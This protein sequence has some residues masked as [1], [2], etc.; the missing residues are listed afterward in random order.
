MVVERV[1]RTSYSVDVAAP[2]GVLYG[3]VADTTQWPLFVPAGVH[4]ERLDFDGTRDR[5]SMWVTA[6]GTVRPSRSRRTLDPE[7][8]RIEFREEAPVAPVTSAGG[9]WS[10]DQLAPGWS[11]LTLEQ[12]VTVAGNRS[13]DVDLV[14]AATHKASRAGLTRLKDVAEKWRSLD[15]LTLTFEDEVR[16]RGPAEPVYAFLYDVA[17][18]PGRIPHVSRLDVVEERPGVQRTRMDTVAADGSVETTESVRVAFPAAGRIV[19]KQTRPSALL[20]AHTGEWSVVPDATGVTVVAQHSVLIG[21]EAVE[22]LHGPGAERAERERLAEVRR[23]VRES[24]GRDSL[25]ILH[26][27]G[28]YAQES[29]RALRAG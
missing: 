21:E 28:Q 1:H 17:S 15:G 20:A 3:L 8:R 22:R 4:V 14:L 5:F 16:L 2:A 13:A 11:R 6:G 27:A 7:R 24:L 18:W 12:Y 19:F 9:S 23:H 26:L 29:V 10:V 25:A